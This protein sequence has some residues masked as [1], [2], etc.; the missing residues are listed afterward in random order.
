MTSPS[1]LHLEPRG[2]RAPARRSFPSASGVALAALASCVSLLAAACSGEQAFSPRDGAALGGAAGNGSAGNGGKGGASAT[3]A[4]GT[5]GGTGGSNVAGT[6]DVGGPGTGGDAGSA[7]T[8]GSA[9]TGGS[10]AGAGGTSGATGAAGG[11]TAGTG[12]GGRGGSGTGGGG[13]GGGGT[14]GGTGGRGNGMPCTKGTDCGSGYC[15]DT[16]CCASDCTGTC[17]TCNG[18]SPGTCVLAPDMTDPRDQCPT[19]TAMSCGRTGTCNGSGACRYWGST[20]VCDS[21]PA[22]DAANGAIVSMKVCNGAG[23]C[24]AGATQSCNGFLCSAGSPP[25]CGTSCTADS[26]CAASGFCS[27][28]VCVAIPN[29][30]GNGD[31]ETGT[32]TGWLAANGGGVLG[33]SA[34]ASSGFAHG[35]GYSAVVSSR[36]F[37]Y[38]GPGYNIPTGP[39]KYI[40]SGWGMQRDLPSISGLLQVRLA[41]QTNVNPG[42]YVTVDAFGVTMTQNVWTQF[43]ATID[44]TTA[45]ADCLPTS[46][47]PGQ[48]RLATLYLNHTTDTVAPFPDLYLDD[49]VVQVTDGHNLVGN[50]NFESGGT[51]GWSLSAGSS[52]MS[53]S[54]TV[55]HGTSTHSLS[56]ASRSIPAAGPRYALPIGAA[57][58]QFSFWVKHNGQQ[59]HDLMLQPTYSC[60]TPAGVVSTAVIGAVL[61]VSPD[62]WTE[63]KGSAT[64]PPPDAPAGCKLNS[65][66]IYVRTDGTACGTGTGQVE[67]PDLY[68]DDVS[69]TLH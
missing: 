31:V 44:T 52:S 17:K 5:T 62:T 32:T 35:G 15:F 20:T 48:T 69:I 45:G 22:C 11:G 66:A 37:A 60:I 28:G 7:G 39:G 49:I 2:R 65:A 30:A 64:F 53:V 3:G 38:Q 29:L 13:T 16:V 56:D 19:E 23:T 33:L 21:T 54:S 63:L 50:P 42:Y 46:A 47:T 12:T 36:N 6:G 40:I 57:R 55:G 26:A 68:V 8:S 59:T 58:Y 14:G 18:A 24:V 51:D 27:A 1:H 61:S 34:V 10:D 4:A 43:S 25:T 9:G 67:C 41:C